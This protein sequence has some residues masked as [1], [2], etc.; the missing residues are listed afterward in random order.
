MRFMTADA[1]ARLPF[2]D[3]S[4]DGLLC[5]DSMNHFPDRLAVFREWHRVLRDGQ[6]AVF[7]DPVVITGPVSNEELAARSSIG[8]FLF[9]PPEVNP[10]LIEQAG[11]R[12]V[13]E[14][15]VT[16]NAALVSGRWHRAREAH[17]E[18]LLEVEGEEGFKSLQ[19]FFESVHRLT[20][21]RRLSRIAYVAEKPFA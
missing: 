8:F 10:R 4:F 7:T 3:D 16:A 17:R 12:L 6:R 5:V 14:E 13:R 15:D 21:E 20:S 1:N 19:R 11:L 2:E 9:A 18:E